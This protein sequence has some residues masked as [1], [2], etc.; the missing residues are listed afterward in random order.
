M[1]PWNRTALGVAGGYVEGS[2]ARRKDGQTGE[3][4]TADQWLD[5][6][7]TAGIDGTV[8]YPTRALGFGR[9]KEREWA[10]ALAQAYNDWIYARFLQASPPPNAIGLPPIQDP[11]A[12]AAA[13]PRVVSEVGMRVGS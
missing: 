3:E 6:L 2:P 4:G 11:A 12:A 9:I 1:E 8:L 5:V 13:P 10:V 7:D